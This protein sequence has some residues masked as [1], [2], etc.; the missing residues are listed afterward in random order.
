MTNR[1]EDPEG[2]VL[3]VTSPRNQCRGCGWYFNSNSAFDMHRTGSVGRLN[4][5]TGKYGLSARRC[6][7]PEEMIA[8]GLAQNEEGYW[9]GSMDEEDKERL[10]ALK[11]S[12]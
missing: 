6:M 12:A 10:K 1:N 9:Q 11:E 3:K 7:T 2:R 8:I 4:P 5:K